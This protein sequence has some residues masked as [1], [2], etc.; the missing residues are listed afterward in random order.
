LAINNIPNHVAII[1]DGNGRWA[2]NKN[3]PR[4]IGHEEGLKTLSKITQKAFDAEVKFLSVYAFSS[5]NWNR[6]K[7]E[8]KHL[9]SLFER[10]IES[11]F[12][13]MVDNNIKF[14]LLGN[15]KKFPSSLQKKIKNLE[16][17]TKKN[18]DY[19]F[20]LAANYGSKE[21]LACAAE[22]LRNSTKKITEKNFKN[23][24]YIP[25]LPDVDLLIRTGGE[26]RLSNF[27]LWQSA[28]AE[29]YFTKT[30]WPDFKKTH[31]TKAL[32]FFSRKVRKFGKIY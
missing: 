4:N 2:K 29:I 24:F 5:E 20:Y 12:Q 1:M 7:K 28:Y 32:K 13:Y 23:A 31:L 14:N 30:L 3:L 9:M 22:N 8:I 18:T 15:I 25:H 17:I 26:T 16:E 19:S 11:N 6:P 10:A 27:L 21:E